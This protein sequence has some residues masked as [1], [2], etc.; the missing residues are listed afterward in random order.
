MIFA[1]FHIPISEYRLLAGFDEDLIRGRLGFLNQIHVFIHSE[2]PD[3]TS[4]LSRLS[5]ALEQFSAF[6]FTDK[7][8]YR[9]P[10]ALPDFQEI[11]RIATYK[12]AEGLPSGFSLSQNMDMDG[13]LNVGST[14]GQ[15]GNGKDDSRR[16]GKDSEREDPDRFVPPDSGKEAGDPDPESPGPE[17]GDARD[18]EISFRV[19]THLHQCTKPFQ[20]LQVKGT[21]KIKV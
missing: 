13:S 12:S 2:P 3:M 7:S 5:P 11:A 15:G 20:D 14:S 4:F 6:V 19:I 8:T 10:S 21:L 16:K 9:L 18:A 17:S 1:D